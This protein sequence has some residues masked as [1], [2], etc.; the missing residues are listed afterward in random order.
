MSVQTRRKRTVGPY[1][2]FLTSVVRTK[3]L[4]PT[5]MRVTL[6]GGDLANFVPV[7]PDTF[8]YVLLP[9]YGRAELT[10]DASF[11][12]EL[13][14]EM[15]EGERPSGAYYT[16]RAH[17]ADV[18]E[19]D[20]DMVLHGD[21]GSGS[22]WAARA[23]PGDPVALWGPRALYDSLPTDDWQLLVGDETALPAISAI[24]ESLDADSRAM[25]VIEVA[26]RAD[27]HVFATRADADIHWVHRGNA[28]AGTS[29]V[30][31]EQVRALE[32]PAGR[33]YAWGGGE[34]RSMTAV[35]R[36]LRD[37]CCLAATDVCVVAYWR[38]ADHAQDPADDE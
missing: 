6:G 10:I 7:G 11:T 19:V 29:S 1:T 30:L 9:P 31:V 14:K 15:A 22:A 12:W 28:E 32:L 13:Y 8:V 24:L 23:Q 5:F 4:S 35:R 37:T 26:R 17:R 33:G 20:L 18:A 2:T 34:S 27:E 21:N 25:A 16:V 36:Y 38:H 3:R